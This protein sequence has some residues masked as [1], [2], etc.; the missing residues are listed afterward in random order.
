M[1]KVFSLPVSIAPI[2]ALSIGGITTLIS[3]YPV[4]SYVLWGLAIIWLLISLIR[5]KKTDDSGLSQSISESSAGRDIYLARGNIIVG[6]STKPSIEAKLKHSSDLLTLLGRLESQVEKINGKRPLGILREGMR[7][8]EFP[9][10]LETGEYDNCKWEGKDGRITRLWLIVE[11]DRLF[12]YLRQ[13]LEGETIWK[14]YEGWKESFRQA[15]EIFDDWERK[16]IGG[17]IKSVDEMLTPLEE[18]Y[19]NLVEELLRIQQKS[20]LPGKCDCCPLGGI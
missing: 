12:K 18:H 9:S 3:G 8:S 11:E 6:E 17:D 15:M 1:R 2:I 16:N 19:D 14:L 10:G 20:M 5:S 4:W 13:H 7:G